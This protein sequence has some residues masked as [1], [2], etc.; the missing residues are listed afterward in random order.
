MSRKAAPPVTRG[1]TDHYLLGNHQESLESGGKLP[2]ARKVLQYL[3]YRQTLPGLSNKPVK[4][5]ICCPLATNSTFAN[6]EGPRG[7]LNSSEAGNMINSTFK[8][9]GVIKTGMN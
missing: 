1:G 7:C 3:K 9:S 4:E 2:L 6:C 8:K 5:I